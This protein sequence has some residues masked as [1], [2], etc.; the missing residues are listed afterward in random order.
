MK[1]K[2]AILPFCM[3]LLAACA[4]SDEKPP[5]EPVT[6]AIT[7]TAATANTATSVVMSEAPTAVATTHVPATLTPTTTLTPAPSATAPA[8]QI[9][10]ANNIDNVV[11]A[12]LSEEEATQILIELLQTNGGCQLPCWWG[13]VPGE[14]LVTDIGARFVPLGFNWNPD[15]H[16]LRDN[17]HYKAS[18][19][20]EAKNGIVASIAVRG[21]VNEDT[22]DKNEAWRPY[23]LP[24][25]LS[26]YGIPSEVYVYYPF[27]F[28]PGGLASYRLFLYY[29]EQ[30]IAIDYLGIADLIPDRN[31][32]AQACPDI[33][34]TDEVNLFL[35]QPGTVPDYRQIRLPALSI[36]VP[37]QPEGTDPYDLIS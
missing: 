15:S 14:T 27:R 6:P 34:R 19:D 1:K 12:T 10:E 23:A 5:A 29:P 20:I 22:Y 24:N 25:L 9:P 7:V 21:G 33:L 13:I 18:V 32:W 8:T 30:G 4:G 36:P 35:F 3:L 37:E 28:D 16:T 31:G 17:T 11:H 2:V 26:A